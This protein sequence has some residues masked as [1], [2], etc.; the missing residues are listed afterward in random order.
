MTVPGQL[1]WSFS[2]LQI[3]APSAGLVCVQKELG[4][5]PRPAFITT[6]PREDE[7]KS[8]SSQR[9]TFAVRFNH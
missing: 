7:L 6:E 5:A 1:V 8:Q 9:F 2:D 3:V 4:C